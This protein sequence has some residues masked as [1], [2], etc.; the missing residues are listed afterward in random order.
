MGRVLRVMGIDLKTNLRNNPNRTPHPRK[1]IYSPAKSATVRAEGAW[2]RG[3][4]LEV[5]CQVS[6]HLPLGRCVAPLETMVKKH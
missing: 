3:R 2:T 6:C 4:P 1:T 5:S